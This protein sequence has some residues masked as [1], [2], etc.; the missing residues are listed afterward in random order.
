M[1]ICSLLLAKSNLYAI[2][3]LLVI[4]FPINSFEDSGYICRFAERV[5]ESRF[6]SFNKD[7]YGRTVDG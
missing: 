4:P 6:F 5:L 7:K 1:V 3:H 2:D